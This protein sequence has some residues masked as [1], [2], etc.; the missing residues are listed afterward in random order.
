MFFNFHFKFQV[1]SVDLDF[2]QNLFPFF[3]GEI[4]LIR[5]FQRDEK[6][7]VYISLV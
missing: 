6:I 7:Y 5:D 3:M 4:F 2:S 1:F